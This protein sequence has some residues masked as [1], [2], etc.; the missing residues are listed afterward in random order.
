MNVIYQVV[1]LSGGYGIRFTTKVGYISNMKAYIIRQNQSSNSLRIITV[2][3]VELASELLN[4]HSFKP[5]HLSSAGLTSSLRF[6]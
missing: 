3:N 4:L 2:K 6:R 1:M 5:Y